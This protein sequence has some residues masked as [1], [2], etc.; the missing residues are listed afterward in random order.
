MDKCK[1]FG[2]KWL[3]VYIKGEYNGKTIKFISCYCDRC[4]KG[5]DESLAINNAAINRKFGTYSE[6]YFNEADLNETQIENAR[7]F[8]DYKE[9]EKILDDILKK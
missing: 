1:W 6:R 2:H 4:R 7:I 3:P 5:Y 9:F 8:N